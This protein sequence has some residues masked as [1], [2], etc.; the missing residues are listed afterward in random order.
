MK[1]IILIAAIAATMTIVSCSKNAEEALNI[2]ES[3]LNVKTNFGNIATRATISSFPAQSAIGLFVTSGSLGS[4]YNTFAGNANVKSV[5]NG[6]IWTQTPEVY[7]SSANATV[8]AYYPYKSSN[9]NGTVIPV[10]HTSQTD[11]MFGTHSSGQTAVNNGNPNVNLTMKHALSL[12]QFKLS[13]INYTGSG[14]VTK[15]EICNKSGKTALCSEGILNIATGAITNI[16]SKNQP[17]VLNVSQSLPATISALVLPVV[18]SIN[19]GDILLN[20]TI[21]GKTYTA[22]IPSTTKW[23]QGKINTYTVTLNGT[24]L[25]VNN[26]GIMDWITGTNGSVV[27]Q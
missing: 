1:A 11:Y 25:V 16:T 5:F 27:L 3:T 7:L 24:G 19:A 22:P 18:S 12:L 14:I 10:E 15:I 6:S 21:D 26:V 4:N 23:E 2:C 9:N 13:K 20:F 8:Y 17:V